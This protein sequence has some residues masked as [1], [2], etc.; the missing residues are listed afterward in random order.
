[1]TDKSDKAAEDLNLPFEAAFHAIEEIVEQLESGELSL[2]DSVA[3]FERGQRLLGLCNTQL[4]NA[5]LR[6][7][8][9][10]AGDDGSLRTESLT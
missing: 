3:L 5:E 6:V 10:S 2:A 8:Q 1:M 9:L 4:D 7:T